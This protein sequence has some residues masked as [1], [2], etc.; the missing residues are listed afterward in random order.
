MLDDFDTQIQCD[1]LD[2]SAY[3]AR[4][5][6][7]RMTENTRV[8]VLN[9]GE[10]WTT[11]EGCAIVDVPNEVMESGDV[12]GWIKDN[13]YREGT[14]VCERE[15][16]MKDEM[17]RDLRNAQAFGDTFGKALDMMFKK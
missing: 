4:I 10:T 9:D 2:D 17:D 3:T 6:E 12:D 5:E 7:E 16:K 1:E 15:R 8:V 14:P 11:I 13:V